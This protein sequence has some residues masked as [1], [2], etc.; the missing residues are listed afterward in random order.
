M[1]PVVTKKTVRIPL[2]TEA[3]GRML[4]VLVA[5]AMEMDREH[6]PEGEIVITAIGDGIHAIDSQHYKGRAID[7]RSKS[8][9]NEARKL[10]FRATYE[11]RLGPQFRVLYESP[12]TDNEHFH[13]QVRI[14]QQYP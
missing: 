11:A 8:F 13:A 5:V 6:V 14:G 4:E 1:L 3:L 2:V 12:G 10:A 9:A 7:I